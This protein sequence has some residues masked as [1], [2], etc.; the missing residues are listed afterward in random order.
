MT[1]YKREKKIY[2]PH[3]LYGFVPFHQV[4]DDDES[5]RNKNNKYQVSTIRKNMIICA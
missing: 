3:K 5:R 1:R 2:I 4:H